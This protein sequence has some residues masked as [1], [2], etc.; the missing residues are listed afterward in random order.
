MLLLPLAQELAHLAPLLVHAGKRERDKLARA[1]EEAGIQTSHHYVPAHSLSCYHAAPDRSS[2]PLPVT[3]AYAER[4]LTLP[5][6]SAMTDAD[7]E[8]VV[9]ALG[10]G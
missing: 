8:A 9:G 4:E 7:L 6:W 2:R 10:P 3:E 5:L 1:L